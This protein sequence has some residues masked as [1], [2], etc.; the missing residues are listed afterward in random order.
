MCGL[1]VSHWMKAEEEESRLP[2]VRQWPGRLKLRSCYSSLTIVA[3]GLTANGKVVKIQVRKSVFRDEKQQQ[4]HHFDS[5]N[6]IAVGVVGFSS[7]TATTLSRSSNQDFKD[8]PLLSRMMLDDD[9]PW[10]PRTPHLSHMLGPV[11][12][13]FQLQGLNMI[14]PCHSDNNN[15]DNCAI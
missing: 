12:V 5:K 13:R 8:I 14:G 1:E 9:L 6:A 2:E 15:C 11:A 4:L 7:T 10:L 3:A